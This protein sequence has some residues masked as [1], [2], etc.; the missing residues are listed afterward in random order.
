MKYPEPL[1]LQHPS[2]YLAIDFNREPILKDITVTIYPMVNDVLAIKGPGNQTWY[3]K[4]TQTFLQTS[5]VEVKW[6]NEIRQGVLRVP[7]QV[8]KVYLRTLMKIVTVRRTNQ[9]LFIV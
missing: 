1:S 7:P 5:Q 3:G 9:G 4:V 2:Y 8:G 6:Y